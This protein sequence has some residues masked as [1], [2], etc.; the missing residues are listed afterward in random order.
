MLLNFPSIPSIVLISSIS[1]ASLPL[2]SQEHDIATSQKWL[3]RFLNAARFNGAIFFYDEQGG[4]I[5]PA[6]NRARTE[7]PDIFDRLGTYVFSTGN[8]VAGSS[9]HMPAAARKYNW[10]I[11]PRWWVVNKRGE[12]T[13]SSTEAPTEE[14]ILRQLDD[15]G[16]RKQ[17]EIY[18]EY[19]KENPYREDGILRLLSIQYELASMKLRKHL[20]ENGWDTSGGRI[21][22]PIPELKRPLEDREDEEIWADFANTLKLAV[23][24]EAYTQSNTAIPVISDP[25]YS[26]HGF[27]MPGHF[28]ALSP[29]MRT[30]ANQ[31]LLRVTQVVR[32]FPENTLVW[33]LWLILERASGGTGS[34]IAPLL[35]SIEPRPYA[36]M[37]FPP[38]RVIQRM[39]E[40]LFNFGGAEVE[41]YYAKRF[42]TL[43]KN[44][45]DE[46][47]DY[48]RSNN[49]ARLFAPA[50]QLIWIYLRQ[51]SDYEAERILTRFIE[52]ANGD[53]KSQ[54]DWAIGLAT[55]LAN[56]G[57]ASQAV[58]TRWREI[59]LESYKNP[60]RNNA[61]TDRAANL[62]SWI[63]IDADDSNDIS[64][65]FNNEI[66]SYRLDSLP[67][68]VK[69]GKRKDFPQF[70]NRKPGW[71]LYNGKDFMFVY[72]ENLPTYD[73]ISTLVSRNGIV[74][75]IDEYEKFRRLNER[76]GHIE[77]DLLKEYL[78]L[79]D[80]RMTRFNQSKPEKPMLDRDE[81]NIIWG[82]IA[83]IL[84]QSLSNGRYRLESINLLQ[85]PGSAS[86]S[87]I[88]KNIAPR[89]IYQLE[90]LIKRDPF[91][92]LNY[93]LYSGINELTGNNHSLVSVLLHMT[94]EPKN[95]TLF[96]RSLPTVGFIYREA[97]KRD[98]FDF[99]V[100]TSAEYWADWLFFWR[101]GAPKPND[102]DILAFLGPLIESLLAKNLTDEAARIFT[103]FME[104]IPSQ[105]IQKQ[106]VQIA[107]K[108]G[109]TELAK[110]WA[111][112]RPNQSPNIGV[113]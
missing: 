103:E 14:E 76:N 67:L 56:A 50:S 48:F 52:W 107:N 65:A 92:A 104:T 75:K 59:D 38:E 43:I 77:L 9:S 73:L 31:L 83:R 81:D 12:V 106:L 96:A 11:E 20:R 6:I 5:A 74:S 16:I 68:P 63:V 28:M 88:M 82:P 23:E 98:E 36:S 111:A 26:P 17:T 44:P 22:F 33:T 66:Y 18:K 93:S 109:K 40:R 101:D 15:A 24:S 78:Q 62:L 72:M 105:E 112:M 47:G 37:N 90:D 49:I 45:V 60:D 27:L 61:P 46:Y 30:L 86:Q 19:I 21:G 32:E 79:A 95:R 110:K 4:K 25:V 91:C 100:D 3:D 80:K 57:E 108:R 55:N 102:D 89:L 69:T 70:A 42:D 113:L 34:A 29:T 58:P 54:L 35:D 64:D 7:N 13:F 87:S 84:D 8:S 2:L 41:K 53:C 71:G 99:I 39:R 85:I 97:L 94:P 1:A 51:N 10:P